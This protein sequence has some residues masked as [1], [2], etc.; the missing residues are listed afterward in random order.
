MSEPIKAD[1][2]DPKYKLFRR[3]LSGITILAQGI[4]SLTPTPNDDEIFNIVAEF[5]NERAEELYDAYAR[6]QA[7][8]AKNQPPFAT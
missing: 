8:R 3:R 4:V 6:K 5:L 1:P 2:N 7:E